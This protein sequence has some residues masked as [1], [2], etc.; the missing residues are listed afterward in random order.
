M[1]RPTVHTAYH[2]VITSKWALVGSV[3]VTQHLLPEPNNFLLTSPLLPS[4]LLPSIPFPFS[5]SPFVT[6]SHY[7][8]KPG[9]KPLFLPPEDSLCPPV[10]LRPNFQCTGNIID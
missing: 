10:W 4:P 8:A 6:Q 3:E 9:L 7:L 2:I 1:H 5:P